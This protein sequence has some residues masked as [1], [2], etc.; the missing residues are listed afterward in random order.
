[1][2]I[3]DAMLDG[4]VFFSH[5]VTTL[6][7]RMTVVKPGQVRTIS[8]ITFNN[9]MTEIVNLNSVNLIHDYPIRL[10]MF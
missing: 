4:D 6:L 2:L 1:M 3:S 7:Q 9:Q 8:S 5:N 10:K